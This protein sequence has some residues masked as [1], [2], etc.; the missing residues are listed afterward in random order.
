MDDNARQVLENLFN[1][2]G[3]DTSCE[4]IFKINNLEN[5]TLEIRGNQP[6]IMS[7]LNILMVECMNLIHKDTKTRLDC[8]SR[9]YMDAKKEIIREGEENEKTKTTDLFNEEDSCEE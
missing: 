7:A 5:P 9:I 3:V 6:A 4:I 2:L 8:L 1:E